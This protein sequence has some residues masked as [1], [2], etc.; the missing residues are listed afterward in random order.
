MVCAKQ[1]YYSKE[2]E[3]TFQASTPLSSIRKE[4]D[5]SYSSEDFYASENLVETWGTNEPRHVNESVS[6][7]YGNLK[8]DAYL[9]RSL[10]SFFNADVTE[11][12][13]TEII[14]DFK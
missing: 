6:Y 9:R 7:I 1:G 13:E 5:D 4:V 2:R 3:S 11:N 8:N 10:R 14:D 12:V